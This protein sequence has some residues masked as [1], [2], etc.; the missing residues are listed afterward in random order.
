MAT[1]PTQPTSQPSGQLGLDRQRLQQLIDLLDQYD[2][3]TSASA[4]LDELC[5]R[6]RAFAPLSQ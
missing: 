5:A 2:L 1:R 6:L 3:S 4:N